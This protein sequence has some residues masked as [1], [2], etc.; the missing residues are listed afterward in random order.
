VD[1]ADVHRGI[2]A[3]SRKY[4]RAESGKCADRAPVVARGGDYGESNTSL[5]AALNLSR[6][7]KLLLLAF[8][9]WLPLYMISFFAIVS[10]AR[11]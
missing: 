4:S 3:R 1:H 9:L 2:V 10:W 5:E 6:P 8:T 11:G 7:L